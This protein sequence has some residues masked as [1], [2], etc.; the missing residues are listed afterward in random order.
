MHITRH[1]LGRARLAVLIALALGQGVAAGGVIA[2]PAPQSTR[3]SITAVTLTNGDVTRIY[4]SGFKAMMQEH[5]VIGESSLA[6]LAALEDQRI[7][8]HG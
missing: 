3:A 2:A 5:G 6:R 4:G 8:A 7:Q 1:T